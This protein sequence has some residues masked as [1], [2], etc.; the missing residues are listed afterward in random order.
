MDYKKFTNSQELH[1]R[2]KVIA[3]TASAPFGVRCQPELKF[4]DGEESVTAYTDGNSIVVN[5]N[6]SLINKE[7]EESVYLSFV[8]MTFHES[9]HCLL[10]DFELRTKVIDLIKRGYF[11]PLDGEAPSSV[12]DEIK[13]AAN[14]VQNAN[15][16]ARIM[17][18]IQNI[19]EDGFIENIGKKLYP[20]ITKK[21]I[22][23]LRKGICQNIIESITDSKGLEKVIN[24]LLLRISTND[25]EVFL[26]EL[27]KEDREFY[28]ELFDLV[29][30]AINTVDSLQRQTVVNCIFIKCWKI[31]KN[32]L[33]TDNPKQQHNVLSDAE[34]NMTP[35]TNKGENNSSQKNNSQKV[36][37]R[38]S[39]SPSSDTDNSSDADDSLSDAVKNAVNSIL[40]DI[41]RQDRNE[42]EEKECQLKDCDY[43]N[44]KQIHDC[45][46]F[47]YDRISPLPFDVLD[48]EVIRKKIMPEK[49]CQLKD[50]DYENNKQI[51]DCIKFN[52]DRISPLPFDVLDL[53]VIRKKIMPIVKKQSKQLEK[54][55]KTQKTY[56]KK[57][58]Y[59]GKRFD[60]RSIV[61]DYERGNLFSKKVVPNQKETAICLLI[62]ESGSMYGHKINIV[63]E[64]A[65]MLYNFCKIIDVPLAIYGH[66]T[67]YNG[68]V[69]HH[70]T[71]Y[72]K[73]YRDDE[74]RLLQI[75]ADGAN[76][77]GFAI[78]YCLQKLMQR[79]EKRKIFI[80]ISDGQP[81]DNNYYGEEAKIDIQ[82]VLKKYKN[83]MS[84]LS[85]GIDED[86]Q[87]LKEIYGE[88]NFVDVTDLENL[89]LELIKRVKR[90]AM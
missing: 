67:D 3:N 17:A 31:I 42:R 16:L 65:I 56:F 70:Y 87:I 50:C 21:A 89:G 60:A 47:N 26:K 59:T 64:A 88:K 37:M 11:Y 80:L 28:Q 75:K 40:R 36:K 58:L 19:V 86:K 57:G 15:I 74:N 2:C 5:K 72:E 8:A 62:D 34:N 43:E 53:E 49:E 12:L 35:L 52:Y 9:M 66:S 46:K 68:V 18:D 77:D 63:R 38:T 13:E 90:S 10:S 69:M 54:L 51:H 71:R 78:D 25:P 7:S 14:S 44:N 20:G 83:R 39:D 32:F 33:N 23:L 55:L 48:L 73:R 85:C 79:R 76:R 27:N 61:D 82:N 30:K 41:K 29:E 4:V 6:S 24:A 22:L 1:R 81:N 45:I 84:Y